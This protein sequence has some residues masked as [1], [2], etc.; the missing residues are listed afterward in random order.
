MTY[1]S[2]PKS[3]V[4]YYLLQ[5]YLTTDC[6]C[7]PEIFKILFS[8]PFVS[9]PPT[10]HHSITISPNH[11]HTKTSNSTTNYT[12]CFF[13]TL[14]DNHHDHNMLPSPWQCPLPAALSRL[15]QPLPYYHHTSSFPCFSPYPLPATMTTQLYTHYNNI[16]PLSSGIHTTLPA[17]TPPAPTT[18]DAPLPHNRQAFT[19]CHI[20]MQPRPSRNPNPSSPP[21]RS[22]TNNN[23]ATLLHLGQST[24]NTPGPH[25]TPLQ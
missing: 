7:P 2:L 17:P 1:N 19:H 6:N 8:L 22:P 15:Y 18:N 5:Q 14:P 24:H 13:S 12:F 21:N 9:P 3:F 4:F 23:T 25:H 16:P 10:D 20:D 11:S